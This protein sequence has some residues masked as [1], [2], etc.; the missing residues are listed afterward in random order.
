MGALEKRKRKGQTRYPQPNNTKT[1]WSV[2]HQN[3]QKQPNSENYAAKNYTLMIY[4]HGCIPTCNMKYSHP[5]KQIHRS[6][7]GLKVSSAQ[8][9]HILTYSCR[10]KGT[11]VANISMCVF[12]ASELDQDTKLIEIKQKEGNNTTGRSNLLSR[13]KNGKLQS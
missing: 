13:C 6:E 8:L 7:Q 5:I 10:M 2:F 1:F 11:I 9:Q 12:P 3:A 4:R